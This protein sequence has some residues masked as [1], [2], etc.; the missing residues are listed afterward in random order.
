M[1]DNAYSTLAAAVRDGRLPISVVNRAV[2]RVLREKVHAGL[3]DDPYTSETRAIALDRDA[4]RSVAQKSIVLLKN[5][6]NLLP[7]PKSGRKIAVVGPLADS[8][9]DMLG[10]WSGQG[11]AEECVTVREA[12]R[13]TVAVEDADVIVAVLGENREM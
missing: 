1:W 9:A 10:P 8:K 3:F 6:N 7:L 5:E 2:R 4:A 11:K 13:D 12:I